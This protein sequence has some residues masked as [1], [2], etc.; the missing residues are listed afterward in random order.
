MRRGCPGFS[1]EVLGSDSYH[2]FYCHVSLF[3]SESPSK[4]DSTSCDFTDEDFQP[5]SAA[6]FDLEYLEGISSEASA[7]PSALSRKSL[8]V[9]FDPLMSAGS[10]KG[11][12]PLG[13]HTHLSNIAPQDG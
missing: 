13:D 6:Q 2:I 1:P 12:V 3:T 4:P 7:D 5:Y 9:K 10:P 11:R 8:F